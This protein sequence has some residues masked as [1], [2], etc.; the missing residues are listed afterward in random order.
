MD[1]NAEDYVEEYDDFPQKTIRKT[2]D[3]CGK[4]L[5]IRIKVKPRRSK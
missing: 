5:H 4:E 1:N 2:C 3:N